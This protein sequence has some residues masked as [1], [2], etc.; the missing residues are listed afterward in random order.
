MLGIEFPHNPPC[1]QCHADIVDLR[2]WLD[3]RGLLKENMN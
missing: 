1:R 3:S 2:K